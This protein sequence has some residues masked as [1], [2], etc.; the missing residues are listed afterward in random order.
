MK[1]HALFMVIKNG[2]IWFGSLGKAGT[3]G[4]GLKGVMVYNGKTFRHISSKGMRNNQVWTVIEDN[5]GNVWIDTK[6]FGLF[7]YDRLYSP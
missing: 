3:G 4:T 5:S 7:R 1:I 2:N 6:E